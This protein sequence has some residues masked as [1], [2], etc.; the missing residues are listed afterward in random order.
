MNKLMIATFLSLLLGAGCEEASPST[1]PVLVSQPTTSTVIFPIAEYG[2][3]RTFKIFGQEVHDRFN[4][5]HLGDDIE[6]EDLKG[7]VPVQAI[8]EGTV[9]YVNAHLSGYGGVIV[10]AHQVGTEKVNALYAHLNLIDTKLR[11]GQRV[12]QGQFLANLGKDRSYQ[13]DGE[14]RHLHFSMYQGDELRLSGYA[15]TKAMVVRWLNPFE[16][17]KQ[18]G[19]A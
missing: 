17:L 5:Y 6:Y 3:R 8:A 1:L 13:T 19:A 16:F 18:Q 7:D 12:T 15:S 2:K 4:G 9:R 10:I 14:R 11:A